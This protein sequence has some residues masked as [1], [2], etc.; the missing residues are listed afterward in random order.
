MT[1]SGK[2]KN[3]LIVACVCTLPSSRPVHVDHVDDDEQRLGR[4]QTI[5]N[6][7]AV[8]YFGAACLGR[9]PKPRLDNRMRQAERYSCLQLQQ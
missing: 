2:K 4:L 5:P 9:W 1:S 8:A 7:K 3:S 6:V